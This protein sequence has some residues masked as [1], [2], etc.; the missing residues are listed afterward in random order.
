MS[1]AFARN[2]A[3]RLAMI[4]GVVLVAGLFWALLQ[5]PSTSSRLTAAPLGGQQS[6]G[7]STTGPSLR[8]MLLA[9]RAREAQI[10]ALLEHP[11]AVHSIAEPQTAP[12]NNAPNP[13][14]QV[15]FPA[16]PGYEAS[17][18]TDFNGYT[19]VS[20]ISGTGTDTVSGVATPGEG[21][22]A[23]T[24]F[25]KGQYIGVD[26]NTYTGTFVYLWIEV[27]QIVTG[28]SFNQTHE[29]H[30]MIPGSDVFSTAFA[31]DNSVTI[32]A[33]LNHSSLNL[34]NFPAQDYQTYDNFSSGKPYD[35]ITINV[36]VNWDSRPRI[37][38]LTN[39]FTGYWLGETAT[40][41]W[42]ASAAAFTFVA[43]PLSPSTPQIDFFSTVSRLRNGVFQ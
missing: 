33:M 26:G 30:V 7:S 5:G 34:T 39:G 9:E 36:T 25:M 19:G 15:A 24:R 12:A 1:I 17:T 35:P 23:D 31:P 22:G 42:S 4:A 2:W 16:L 18:I 28:G 14:P 38:D 43:D 11:E 37:V 13:I 29:I 32:V 6:S 27:F 8:L 41:Q 10:L 21:F 20:D 40:I 3:S